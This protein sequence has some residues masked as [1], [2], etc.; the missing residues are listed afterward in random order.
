M[1]WHLLLTFMMDVRQ[2]Q[3]INQYSI[4]KHNSLMRLVILEALGGRVSMFEIHL[5]FIVLGRVTPL[6]RRV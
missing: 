1:V 6:P 2:C 5:F 4:L 3:V